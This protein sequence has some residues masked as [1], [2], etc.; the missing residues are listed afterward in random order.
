MKLELEELENIPIPTKLQGILCLDQI[1][2]LDPTK[3][4]AK[5]RRYRQAWKL[6]SPY[7]DP[8]V[9]KPKQ[10]K[11]YNSMVRIPKAFEW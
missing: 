4:P 6:G 5:K 9:K 3:E 8:D 1:I 7:T 2:S 11:A 10:A